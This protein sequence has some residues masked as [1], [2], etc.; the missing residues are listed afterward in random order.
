MTT[1]TVTLYGLPIVSGRTVPASTASTR[2]A[3][4]ELFIRHAAG[5]AASGRRTTRSSPA[6]PRSCDRVRRTRGDR[7]RRGAICSTTTMLFDFYDERRRPADVTSARHFDRWWKD[8]ARRSAPARPHRRRARPAR[9]GFRL[10]DFPD[11]WR[12]GDLVLPLIV[13]LRPGRP[14]RRRDG[15]RPADRRSTRS[16]TT[17]ST[18]RSPA[19]ARELVERAR[20]HAAQG[21]PAGR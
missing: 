1:E 5:R 4:R 12:Q 16:P 3:A 13:P 14:A 19:I 18:G 21:R 20:A 11:A 17:A 2:P 6:T 10:A 8:A 9:R 7:V 15:A